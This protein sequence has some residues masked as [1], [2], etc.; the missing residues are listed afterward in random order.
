MKPRVS[1]L[2]LAGL[3]PGTAWGQAPVGPEFRINSTTSGSQVFPSVAR[4]GVGNFVVVWSSFAQDGDGFGVFGRRYDA[5]G[6]P[7]GG[8]FQV[9][10]Y[11]TNW[12][13][14]PSVTSD[15]SGNFVVIWASQRPGGS[16]YD[17]FGRHFDALGLAQGAEFQVNSY[18]TSYQYFPAV[19]ALANGFVVVWTS[20]GQDGSGY[21]V[22][23]RRFDA[24]GTPQGG[25][26]RLNSYTTGSQILPAVAADGS[27]NFVVVWD[28]MR[29]DD[30]SGVW[31][32]R[33]DSAGTSVGGEFRVNSYTSGVQFA[34]RIHMTSNGAFVIVWISRYQDGDAHGVF[35]QRYDSSGLPRG[36]E[37]QV[38]SY[39]TGYQFG[40]SVATASNGDFLVAWTSST[41]DGS[42]GG[43]FGQRYDSSGG[44]LGGEF[45]VNSYTTAYQYFAGVAPLA[46]GQFVVTWQSN[47]QDG[48]GYGV[49]AQRFAPDLIFADGFE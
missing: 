17:V 8:E 44:R 1:V 40:A 43:V 31:G 34:P 13:M 29:P 4:D 33:F 42:L 27:G 39:S 37:F 49:F 9:N 14:R 15:A 12:Q 16:D 24:S 11:T 23:G 10:S 3:L 41:Q 6:V 5:S 47:G 35:G 7:R 28:G 30:D 18:T 45:Q 38:N 22:F 26:F 46:A 36:S 25:E 20:N 32:Q 19:A 2:V 48:G 21:G